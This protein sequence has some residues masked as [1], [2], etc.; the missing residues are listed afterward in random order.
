MRL[1]LKTIGF[2]VAKETVQR[3]GLEIPKVCMTGLVEAVNAVI[4]QAKSNLYEYPPAARYKRTG[5]LGASLEILTQTQAG[6]L[7]VVEAGSLLEYAFYQ[8]YGWTT[9]A[10]TSVPGKFYF[11]MAMEQKRY[12]FPDL[13]MA[14]VK[15]IV[16]GG[17][18]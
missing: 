1:E 12:E 6:H 17:G 8:E 11:T 9:R 18:R 3:L 16:P 10:G 15:A 14:K 13:L 5:R 7:L 4:E 2:D